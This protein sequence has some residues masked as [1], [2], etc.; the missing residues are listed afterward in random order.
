M[1][2]RTVPPEIRRARVYRER[3]RNIRAMGFKDYADYLKSDL[4]KGI[5][6]RVLSE[7]PFCKGCG[8][9]ATQ[10]HHSAYRKKDLEGR[11]L[12]RLH[13]TCGGCHFKAEFRRRDGA[14][15]NPKQATLK[16]KQ[17]AHAN[18]QNRSAILDPLFS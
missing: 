5:R 6:A 1:K 14:K 11:D 16:L 13:S 9:D 8:K 12:R 18:A 15:L 17:M 2:R 3:N 4:W 7:R 10:V